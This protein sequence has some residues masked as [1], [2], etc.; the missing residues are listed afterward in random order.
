MLAIETLESRTMLV[1]GKSLDSPDQEK[2][3]KMPENVGKM[4]KNVRKCRKCRESGT[5]KRGFL[6]GDFC[7]M[8]ASLGCGVLS[9]K[10]TAGANI[11]GY[12]LFPWP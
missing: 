4:S 12:F 6:E 8:Y 5:K 7:K 3:D 1:A 11:L 9:A 2:H 10:C